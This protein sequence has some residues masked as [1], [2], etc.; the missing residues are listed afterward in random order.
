MEKIEREKRIVESMIRLYCRGKEGNNELCD[1]C[2]ALLTYAHARL[3]RCKFGNDKTSCKR[4]PIHCYKPDM[5]SRMR[6]VMRYSGP[7]MLFH[8]PITALRHI[9][10]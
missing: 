4:C 9:F 10:E 3:S 6:Q 1:D 5:R 2:R 8:H 7:R